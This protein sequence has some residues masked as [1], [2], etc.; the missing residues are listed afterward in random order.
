[1]SEHTI[2]RYRKVFLPD[3]SLPSVRDAVPVIPPSEGYVHD[4]HREV[5]W[6]VDYRGDNDDIPTLLFVGAGYT[7]VKSIFLSM[8]ALGSPLFSGF[9]LYQDS[10]IY[11]RQGKAWV[12]IAIELRNY[13][14]ERMHIEDLGQILACRIQSSCL[15]NIKFLKL[16]KFLNV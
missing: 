3:P 15:C 11:Q 16:D 13:H 4:Y 2:S 8:F 1:M 7:L 9:R 5:A 12:R 14:S 6:T 10:Y